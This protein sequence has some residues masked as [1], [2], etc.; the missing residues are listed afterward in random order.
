[1][2]LADAGGDS[3]EWRLRYG[4]LSDAELAEIEAFFGA[5]EGR[6]CS[7]TFL[8]PTGNLL[9]WSEALDQAAWEKDPLL[10][11]TGGIADAWGTTRAW[12]IANAGAAPQRIRQIISAPEWFQYSLSLSARSADTTEVT[13]L[14]GSESAVRALSSEWRRLV[15]T[16]AAAGTAESIAFG[17]ELA[18]GSSVEVCGLQVEPQAGASAYRQTGSQGGVYAQARL[19]NDALEIVSTGPNRH[20]CILD[21]IHANHI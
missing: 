12:R 14:R 11:L 15:F 10:A 5:V 7:F 16:A 6:L 18:A 9:A 13:L 21:V 3:I 4:A 20:S 1:V 17:L 8:D 2:K 19:A